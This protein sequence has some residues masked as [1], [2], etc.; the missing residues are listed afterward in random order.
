MR[1][2]DAIGMSLRSI[3]EKPLE[4]GLIALGV[5]LS[6]CIAAAS[7][8]LLGSQTKQ[9]EKILSGPAYR[10]II[11][12]SA[13]TMQSD[14]QTAIRETSTGQD[15]NRMRMNFGEADIE[16]VKA[17]VPSVTAGYFVSNEIVRVGAFGGPG[18]AVAFGGAARSGNA[19]TGTGQPPGQTGSAQAATTQA[20]GAQSSSAQ[21]NAAVAPAAGAPMAFDAP[22]DMPEELRQQMQEFFQG[23]ADVDESTLLSIAEENFSAMEVSPAFFQAYGLSA[24]HGSLFTE[25]DAQNR[26][27]NMV[28]LGP[29]LAARLFPDMKAEELIGR[30]ARLN[31]RIYTLTG[32]LSAD[33]ALIS[34]AQGMKL[35]EA[36]YLPSIQIVIRQGDRVIQMGRGQNQVRFSVASTEDLDQAAAGILEYFQATYGEEKVSLSVP[37]KNAQLS[38]SSFERLLWL[39]VAFGLGGFAM[40]MI[41]LMNMMLTRAM[42]RQQPLG[43]LSAVGASR[44]DIALLQASEGGTLALVGMAIGLGLS[45]PLYQLLYKAGEYLFEL[46]M[47]RIPMDAGVFIGVSVG[48]LVLSLLLALLP[49]V[50]TSRVEIVSALKNE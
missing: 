36:A 34:T 24:E 26:A 38:R 6:G 37:F 45:V 13:D 23:Q 1:A 27:N 2:H 10:E 29:G 16:A 8:L 9:M 35:S 28:V 48:L 17:A 31:G 50:Q 44:A 39:I 25:E 49:A 32:I 43:I 33:S 42:R 4:S 5:A 15:R 12:R 14:D 3:K 18:M 21:A 40:A 20:A 11:V 19:Q 47:G 41:N 22:P 30:K 46:G 7:I